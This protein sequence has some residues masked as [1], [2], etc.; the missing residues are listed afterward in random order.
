MLTIDLTFIHSF[1]S[2]L[3]CASVVCGLNLCLKG[4]LR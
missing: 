1:V 4:Y 3:A 2:V